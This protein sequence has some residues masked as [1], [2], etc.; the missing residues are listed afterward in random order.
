M[1]IDTLYD[2]EMQFY[3]IVSSIP[4]KRNLR[5]GLPIHLRKLPL[6]LSREPVGKPP[7]EHQRISQPG[8]ELVPVQ[9]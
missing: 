7:S 9:R 2:D 1:F 3:F 8:P 5:F 6:Q 4:L